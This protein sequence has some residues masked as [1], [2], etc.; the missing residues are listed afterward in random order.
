[1]LGVVLPWLLTGLVVA[2]TGLEEYIL[3]SNR[4]DLSEFFLP[5]SSDYLYF[6]LLRLIDAGQI[7]TLEYQNLRTAF[8]S[9]GDS[10]RINRVDLRSLLK[11]WELTLSPVE[12]TS[13]LAEINRKYF[14]CDVSGATRS[15]VGSQQVFPSELSALNT[16]LPDSVYSDYSAFTRLTV[17]G[18]NSMDVSRVSDQVLPVY[19]QTA[20][21]ATV[22]GVPERLN[23]YLRVYHVSGVAPYF[24]K[25]TL[26]QL[27]RLAEL[28]VGLKSESVWVTSLLW[29]KHPVSREMTRVALHSQLQ[30]ALQTVQQLATVPGLE[31]EL[32]FR[33]L[34]LGLYTGHHS[35]ALF[36]RYLS[37]K[38]DNRYFWS[39]YLT[40]VDQSVP[41][42]PDNELIEEYAFI[43][44]PFQ[45][46][47]QST[48]SSLLNPDQLTF[49]I[50]KS[51]LLAGNDPNQFPLPPNELSA[52][53]ST[54]ELDFERTNSDTF[55]GNDT[56]ILSI[57]RKNIDKMTIS[58]IEF[59]SEAYYRRNL[60]AIPTDLSLEGV[61]PTIEETRSYTVSPLVRHTETLEIKALQGKAGL[62]IVELTAE[63]VN[64]RAWVKKGALRMA[65]RSVRSGVEVQVY[66]ETGEK[67]KK[68]GV[69]LD[70]KLY[71]GTDSVI[72]PFSQVKSEKKVVIVGDGR[73]ELVPNFVHESE[74][75]ELKMGVVAQQESLLSGQ[76]V[77]VRITPKLY[78]NE[79]EIGVG[80]VEKG[81]MRAVMR[82]VMG[83]VTTQSWQ[84]VGLTE[85]GVVVD[86]DL[87]DGVL[88]LTLELSGQI[89]HHN[90]ASYLDLQ[91]S[92]TL[93]AND[94]SFVPSVFDLYFQSLLN[95][96]THQ[97]HYLL[98]TLGKNGEPV[99]NVIIDIA[100]ETRYRTDSEQRTLQSDSTGVILL[101]HLES[102][103]RLTATARGS[104]AVT[105]SWTV[106]SQQYQL[107]YPSHIYIL[108]TE[109][110]NFPVVLPGDKHSLLTLSNDEIKEYRELS[111]VDSVV[112][113]SGVEEG[114]Y[115]LHITEPTHITRIRLTVAAGTRLPNGLLSSAKGLYPDT[116]LSL[117][118]GIASISTL[119]NSVS[120]TVTG[121]SV[122]SKAIFLFRNFQN[123][124]PISRFL[125]YQSLLT[126][127][128]PVFPAF[129]ALS[130]Y[131][132]SRLLDDEYRYIL[133]RRTSSDKVGIG[134]PL[135][136]LLLR[137]K[138]SSDTVT[139][140]QQPE[141][142]TP[143][144]PP[145][146]APS[147]PTS[148]DDA[149]G[150]S[151]LVSL[152]PGLFY[153]FLTHSALFSQET[154]LDHT[155]TATLNC[156]FLSHFSVLEVLIRTNSSVSQRIFSL[157]PSNLSLKPQIL[158]FSLNSSRS[159]AEIRSISPLFPGNRL[160]INDVSSSSFAIIDSVGKL[161]K[162]LLQLGQTKGKIDAKAENWLFLGNWNQYSQ[163]EKEK[164]YSEKSGHELNLFLYYKDPVFFMEIVRPFLSSK[165]QKTAIDDILLG[166][167]LENHLKFPKISE[168]S[169][170]EQSLL[171][172]FSNNSQIQEFLTS[173]SAAK[174]SSSQEKKWLFDAVMRFAQGDSVTPVREE[175][176]ASSQAVPETNTT[177]NAQ[178][179][180]DG[181]PAPQSPEFA[182]E[183][184]PKGRPYFRQVDS[185][186]EY[187]ESN[188]ISE[189]PS[190]VGWEFW[191]Q[192]AS[193]TL[194]ETV[195]HAH[196]SLTEVII[197]VGVTDLPWIPTH[198]PFIS[199][200][201]GA[202]MEITSNCIVLHRDVQTVGEVEKEDL[203]IA[204]Y[205]TEPSVSSD[206]YRPKEFVKGRAYTSKVV[207]TNMSSRLYSLD[208]L[209]Q[210]PQG[211]IP[212]GSFQFLQV[213]T[214]ELPP[215]ATTFSSSTFYFPEA[216]VFTHSPAWASIANIVVKSTPNRGLLT[217]KT[218]E[219]EL[220][221]DSFRDIT[222]AGNKTAVLNFLQSKN[223]H[224]EAVGVDYRELEW[225]LV[226][227]TFFVQVTEVLRRRSVYVHS[228]W[229]FS[230]LHG[231]LPALS[232]FLGSSPFLTSTVGPAFQ[233]QLL[234][235]SFPFPYRE[236]FPL[237][238]A[239]AHPLGSQSRITNQQFRATY[240]QWLSY[241]GDKGH[242][243]EEDKL[244]FVQYLCLQ[245][246]YQLAYHVLNTVNSTVSPLQN[247]YL[248]AFLNETEARNI[249]IEYSNY[250]ILP[251]KRRFQTISEHIIESERSEIA[252]NDP[253]T[254]V[255]VVEDT[256]RIISSGTQA[257]QIRIHPIDLEV[258]F[259]RSPF[260]HQNTE[261][262]SYT[263]PTYTETIPITTNNITI[264]PLPEAYRRGNQYL[265]V[266]IA[267]QEWVELY[268]KSNL[269]VQV[270]EMQGELKVTGERLEVVRGAYVKVYARKQDGSVGFYKDGYTDIRGRF[271]YATLSTN[272]LDLVT[273]FS[274]LVASPDQ[275]ATV[276]EVSPPPHST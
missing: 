74:K 199:S 44:F 17:L 96:T 34:S 176:T 129:P 218:Q 250:P 243:Q 143:F 78:L 203:A 116:S 185:T 139:E 33:V 67:T 56:V 11:R 215:Y 236:Y 158:P 36:Q 174:S 141:P 71:S 244:C 269:H 1:M 80:E 268:L 40:A 172:H 9:Q 58:I 272:D 54:V 202:E 18:V 69:V 55:T 94:Q 183:E 225:M 214:I 164:I 117:P 192:V 5:G 175:E 145:V 201:L 148:S 66:T 168:I 247:A 255:K 75:Y 39:N 267:G 45:P 99:P 166:N 124:S 101:G 125:Q 42:I 182:S 242:L 178:P 35:E 49:L 24:S 171:A 264:Y 81:S 191:S 237:I 37:L 246:R 150:M 41:Y 16:D 119:T 28:K 21:L 232:E 82:D 149:S 76:R 142:G 86:V 26:A 226:E 239:R 134:Y 253:I 130:T 245:G 91:A 251:W 208:L 15:A 13:I 123:E 109:A 137:P 111:P 43:Y 115:L 38:R 132:R 261:I 48:Y 126:K 114:E 20:D 23:S 4:T 7:A 146:P 189:A 136:S 196:L 252:S 153:D 107:S 128:N 73:A 211:S 120:V 271:G 121:A 122:G 160:R 219:T 222:R 30:N 95:S 59:S 22:T 62:F 241:I 118:L 188:Y 85:R 60:N 133:D 84:E 194:S 263:S 258:L 157:S 233:S 209:L 46:N 193:H 52:L 138:E 224:D 25:M 234:S 249:L 205:Y 260:L 274:I 230:L 179:S 53:A 259:S 198:R 65:A 127:E 29:K 79:A 206:L 93:E 72:L 197:A 97:T 50:A 103:S 275:G 64:A 257:A 270:W 87:P 131:L 155:G 47:I 221:L 254:E 113:V 10:T 227:E 8:N 165:L 190:E 212:L 90:T 98:K 187:I 248:R 68:C 89:Y 108:P 173:K 170:I 169:P 213:Q 70:G 104:V 147:A 181:E 102:I 83:L 140:V 235:T 266:E 204:Q 51:N 159:Y 27:L 110:V 238:N 229:C 77:Q 220:N 231:T 151:Q 32:L 200:G 161:L 31:R 3:A 156:E 177:T 14:Q 6:S 262:C 167:S 135:P 228:V 216:G 63:G 112:S 210:I 144:T 2:S 92:Y 195:L 106:M 154:L 240:D 162:V 88:S 223:I 265:V 61:V 273:R 19:L 12:Q 152:S 207:L 57:R 180:L 100:L 217:V 276:L 256:I 163:E 105:R 186:K 184:Q